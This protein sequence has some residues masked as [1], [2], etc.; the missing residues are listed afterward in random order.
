MPRQPGWATYRRMYLRQD[1]E[2]GFV[3]KT[4]NMTYGDEKYVVLC[5]NYPDVDLPHGVRVFQI[6][7]V[8]D[9]KFMLKN[10]RW[11][12]ANN[13]SDAVDVAQEMLWDND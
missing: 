12:P 6:V 7:R 9:G 13:L 8:K 3:H 4:A 11:R 2:N 1:L 10:N 5:E